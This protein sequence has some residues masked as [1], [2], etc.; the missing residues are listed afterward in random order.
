MEFQTLTQI[1]QQELTELEASLRQSL[2]ND[3]PF[4]ETVSDRIIH[5]GGKRMRP[6]VL[7][8]MSKALGYEGKKHI[9]LGTII[10]FIHTATLL[11][12]DV[13][14]A[15]SM[16][17]G[18]PTANEVWGNQAPVLVGDFLYSRAFQ[19]MIHLNDMSIMD[20]LA[21]TTNTISRGEVMQ[22]L[23]TH[24]VN[25]TEETY[26]QTIYNKTAILF[27]T[28][29]FL[30]AKISGCNES[31]SL[32]L[33]KFGLHF[34]IAFQL[35][36]DVLDYMG[37][38]D[39]TG[40]AT[41]NDLLEGKMTLPLIHALNHCNPEEK[42][43]I[44]EN[45]QQGSAKDFDQIKQIIEKTG[46]IEYVMEVAQKEI[47]QGEATLESLPPS[48]YRDALEGLLEFAQVRVF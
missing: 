27:E 13:V 25:A 20:H 8:L 21:E 7:L 19:L 40:K 42:K 35:I 17:R 31:K 36:D 33:G 23:N 10:E 11:H 34:G 28:S 5:S 32:R 24:N 41:C 47:S 37:D 30:G 43:L 2:E 4:I 12:D 3:V 6:V 48:Q 29:A 26:F 46:A 18:K 1:L 15:S 22:L 38:P 9:Q 44:Q 39:K 14:D 45:V 16:R